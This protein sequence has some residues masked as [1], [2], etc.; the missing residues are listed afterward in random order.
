MFTVVKQAGLFCQ[1]VNYGGKKV[2]HYSSA[3]LDIS[4]SFS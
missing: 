3:G 2:L 1:I 4:P